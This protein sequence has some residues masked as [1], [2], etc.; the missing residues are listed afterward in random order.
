MVRPRLLSVSEAAAELNAS[1]AYVRRLLLRQRLYG[2]KVGPVWAIFPDDLAMFK[3]IRR[4]P[5]RP[6]KAS[7]LAVTIDDTEQMDKDRARAGTN[8]ALRRPRRSG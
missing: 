4:R 8:R 2:I 7:R 6:S 3:L 1:E 5:G